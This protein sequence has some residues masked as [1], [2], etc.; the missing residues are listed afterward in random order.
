MTNAREI[1]TM[2]TLI[3]AGLEPTE[4]RTVNFQ[5]IADAAAPAIAR[6]WS[7]DEIARAALANLDQAKSIGAVMVAN[8][9]QLAHED[10]PRT[11]GPPPIAEVLADMHGRHTPG[12]HQA[13]INRIRAQ[14]EARRRPA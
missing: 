5:A 4:I 12:D 1:V 10:P 7:G 8:V 9:R 6:G 3:L 14:H 11:P 2:R 13:W